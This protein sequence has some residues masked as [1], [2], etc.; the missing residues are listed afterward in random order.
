MMLIPNPKM[1]KRR[2]HKKTMN[3]YVKKTYLTFGEIVSLVVNLPVV[4]YESKKNPFLTLSDESW[5]VSAIAIFFNG[6]PL[7]QDAIP[8]SKLKCCEWEGTEPPAHWELKDE[9][10]PFLEMFRE[11]FHDSLMMEKPDDSE[12]IPAFRNWFT[13]FFILINNTWDKYS[14]IL[15]QYNAL[16][17]K[18]IDGKES[19]Y[20]SE[21]DTSANGTNRFNDT[22][23]NS[24][25]FD[26]DSHT[27]NLNESESSG[28]SD[29]EVHNFANDLYNVEKLRMLEEKFLDVY[30]T[31]TNEVGKKLFFTLS[32][33]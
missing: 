11:R 21:T 26:D 28:S 15:T 17:N 7:D 22:P 25:L 20:T 19:G 31:W 24:G 14:N 33:E 16:K 30:L 10:K 23:Q 18:L 8:F 32:Y 29:T 4:D 3:K 12:I 27:S 5:F 9:I 2:K 6:D 1:L 13:R